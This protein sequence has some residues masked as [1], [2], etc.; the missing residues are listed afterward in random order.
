MHPFLDNDQP[1]RGAAAV[2]A[3]KPTGAADRDP[4]SPEDAAEHLRRANIT[5]AVHAA[6]LVTGGQLFD[7]DGEPL[8]QSAI[9]D[10]WTLEDLLADLAEASKHFAKR[11][12]EDDDDE[13]DEK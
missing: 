2:R 1:L 7:D 11:G 12:E 6:E 4:A 13:E 3:A 5:L 10:D 8:A 9:K